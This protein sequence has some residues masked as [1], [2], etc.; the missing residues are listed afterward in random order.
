MAGIAD[1]T[2][3]YYSE[4]SSDNDVEL[5]N[6]TE[7]KSDFLIVNNTTIN[8][9]RVVGRYLQ[10]CRLLHSIAPHIILCMT[11]L[12]DFYIY[13]VYDIFGK[14][15]PVPGENLYT[16]PLNLN[17]KRIFREVI[18]KVKVWPP[19]C[20]MIEQ[21][22]RDPEQLFGLVKR[23]NGV[24]S[25]VALI[26]QFNQLQ[27]YL[28]HLILSTN[29]TINPEDTEKNF[30]VREKLKRFVEETSSYIGDLRKP[31]YMCVTSRVI[32]IQNI[33]TAMN[34]VKWDINH[35]TVEHSSYVD[36]INRV[37]PTYFLSFFILFIIF[38]NFCLFIHFIL[39]INSCLFL[40][41]FILFSHLCQTVSSNFRCSLGRNFSH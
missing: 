36:I 2:S 38:I 6:N 4:D 13:A 17:L 39:L 37:S 1:E 40:S 14:D 16:E 29:S 34:K 21:D 5:N 9:L 31:I 10:M 20:Q 15:L 25:C 3:C 27:G 41:F 26:Q 19:S 30:Q 33:L 7:N 23:I 24:E 35:V 22:L 12:I 28:E 11:E 18:S 8:V 32:D